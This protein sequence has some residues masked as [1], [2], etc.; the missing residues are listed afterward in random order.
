MTRLLTIDRRIATCRQAVIGPLC[1]AL[2][3]CALVSTSVAQAQNYKPLEGWT[4]GSGKDALI[5]LVHEGHGVKPYI[6]FG[7]ELA[8]RFPSTTVATV[9]RPGYR[10]GGKRSSGNGAKRDHLTR[11]NNA[12]LAQSI[13]AL[14][15]S[16]GISRVIA[17]GHADGAG[18]VGVVI[19]S[20]RGAIDTAILVSCPC[21]VPR[22]RKDLKGVDNWGASQSPHKYVAKIPR[23]T[24]VVLISGNRDPS[25]KI[26]LSK[27]YVKRAKKTGR[28]VPLVVVKGAG[29][30]L[31]PL[32]PAII[33]TLAGLIR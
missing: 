8:A 14:K 26:S 25:T 12:L 21:N 4:A 22:W 7:K 6:T 19:G 18:Q 3:L 20:H 33:Q 2:F 5:V 23:S 13:S 1:A 28:K 24:D 16:T 17:V 27:D 30:E 11:E 15:A 31:R 9:L 10:Y 29:H 32:K